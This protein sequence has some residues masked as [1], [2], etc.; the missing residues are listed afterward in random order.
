MHHH[1]QN[2]ASPNGRASSR[3]AAP[4]FLTA[5]IALTGCTSSTATGSLDV[6]LEAEDTV[7]E[8][9]TPGTEGESIQDGWTVSFNRY[10]AAIG[11]IHVIQSSDASVE[12]EALE[13]H[14]VDLTAL[15][16]GAVSLWSFTDLAEGRWDFNYE[17][18]SA[19]ASSIRDDSVS[20]EDF[21][22]MVAA[23]W[24]YL[25]DGTLTKS[26]GISCPPAALAQPGSAT[27][28]GQTNKD[29]DP[30]YDAPSISFMFGATAATEFGP[31]EIDEVPG[32]SVVANDTVSA[33][34]SIHGDHLFFNGFPEG[35]E[36]GVSR[37]AQWMADC[38]L[39]LDGMVT[40][41]ELMAIAPEQLSEI[42]ERYQL[43]GS[44]ITPLNNMYEY[45]RAQMKTQ[46]HFQGEGECALDGVDAH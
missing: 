4:M 32:V 15:N 24:T 5:A 21:D 29:G 20:A 22:A 23:G 19:T 35:D 44:P 40:A 26:D 10:I 45:L 16:A 31:C 25:V 9:L 14:V 34:A 1:N 38:D 6:L 37:L 41:E 28:N 12:E 18:P 36:G 30:C 11:P 39:N 3:R 2:N 8:G 46:G 43:G 7:V 27:S 13:T 42:D 17:T 33:A